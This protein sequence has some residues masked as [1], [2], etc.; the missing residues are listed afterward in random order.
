MMI[1]SAE[2]VHFLLGKDRKTPFLVRN[3]DEDVV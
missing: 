3:Y 1:I 2:I